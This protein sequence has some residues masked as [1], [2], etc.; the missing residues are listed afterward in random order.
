ML[1]IYA[2]LNKESTTCTEGLD[3]NQRQT[4]ESFQPSVSFYELP[5]ATIARRRGRFMTTGASRAIP[6]FLM[7]INKTADRKIRLKQNA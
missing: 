4:R 6:V 1:T 7:Q 2:S 3:L 5:I